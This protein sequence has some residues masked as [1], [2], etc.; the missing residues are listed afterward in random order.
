MVVSIDGK[1]KNV[2]FDKKKKMPKKIQFNVCPTP[3]RQLI[4]D[5]LAGVR[6]SSLLSKHSKKLYHFD[7]TQVKN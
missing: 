2:I 7:V 1:V 6:S 4:H 3:N 5:S